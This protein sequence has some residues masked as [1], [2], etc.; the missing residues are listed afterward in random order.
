MLKLK[1]FKGGFDRNLSYV[2]Y[3][4]ESKEAAIIDIS[5]E[6]KILIDFIKE[7]GLKLKFAVIMHSHF[8]HLNGYDYYREEGIKLVASEQIKKAVDLKLKDGDELGSGKYSNLGL[9]KH[10]LKVI[11]T[12]GHLFDAI[13]LLVEGKLFTSDT[14]FIGCCGRTDLD[15]A[16]PE[17]MKKSLEKI[18][19][20]PDETIIYPGH[21]YSSVPFTTLGEQKE[22]NSYLRTI[23]TGQ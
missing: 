14:L 7:E 9:G 20:L 2:L 15:G 18:K 23:P 11:H 4:D 3:D 8:D 6:P 5:V 1:T 12:P 16:D 21:D 10:K 22:S 17:E 19:F 13:C